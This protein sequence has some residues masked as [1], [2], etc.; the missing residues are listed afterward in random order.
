M[1]SSWGPAIGL[2]LLPHVGGLLGGLITRR[3]VKTWYSTLVKPSWRPPNWMFGPVW[4]TLYTAMGYGSYLVYKELGGFTEDAVVPLGLYAGQ[5]A[6][7]WSWTPIFF[8]YHKMGWGLVDLVL[9]GGTAALT[10]ITWYPINKTAGLLML[11]YLAWLSVAIT[12]NYCVWRD[13]KDKSE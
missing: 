9:I 12:L 6:L 13:N 3:E 4:T 10:T 5:L 1:P 2:T 8:G 7:N 11:P